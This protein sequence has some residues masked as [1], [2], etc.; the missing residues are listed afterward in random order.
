MQYINTYSYVTLVYYYRDIAWWWNIRLDPKPSPGGQ[1]PLSCS[2]RPG[3]C[4]PPSRTAAPPGRFDA[5]PTFE[6]HMEFVASRR[7]HVHVRGQRRLGPILLK[8]CPWSHGRTEEWEPRGCWRSKF[9]S[10]NVISIN[11]MIELTDTK[12]RKSRKLPEV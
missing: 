5:K 4:R 2:G 6:Y 1:H 9:A 12:Q 3:C 7:R 10:A 8:S 11:T